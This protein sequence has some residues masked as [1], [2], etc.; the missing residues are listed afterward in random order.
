MKRILLLILIPLFCLSQNNKDDNDFF[1]QNLL[2]CQDLDETLI[3]IVNIFGDASLLEGLLGC[4]ELIP[5]LESGILSAFLPFEIPLDCGTDLT[6]FGYLDVNL[7]DICQCSCEPFLNIININNHQPNLIKKVDI[8]GKESKTSGLF[9]EL[10][11]D[12]TIIKKYQLLQ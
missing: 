4:E 8:L 10:Y 6:P 11:D 2:G 12:G 9:F 1:T 3:D 5:T 7:Y